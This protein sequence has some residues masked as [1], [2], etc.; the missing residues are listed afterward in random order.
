MFQ[1]SISDCKRW[2]SK[3]CFFENICHFKHDLIKQDLKSNVREI[4]SSCQ[5]TNYW[6]W[7]RENCKLQNKCWY[8]HDSD[9]KSSILKNLN[10]TN[11]KNINLF[12]FYIFFLILFHTIS[13]LTFFWSFYYRKEFCVLLCHLF[14]IEYFWSVHCFIE[15][16]TQILSELIRFSVIREE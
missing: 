15:L 16:H 14:W 9:K 5:S 4:I 7:L 11:K 1:V 13:K 3:H 6:Y 8:W 2:L 12:F 10:A